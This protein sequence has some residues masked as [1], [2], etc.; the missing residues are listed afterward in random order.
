MNKC[1]D[2]GYVFWNFSIPKH[3]LEVIRKYVETGQRPGSFLT[4]V[5]CNDLRT[6]VAQADDHN[7]VNLRAYLAYLHNE[8]PGDCWG[9]RENMLAWIKSKNGRQ[10][11]C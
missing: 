2:P 1:D 11:P 10:T 6:A 9:S 8:A 5:I 3:M 4:A 7:I